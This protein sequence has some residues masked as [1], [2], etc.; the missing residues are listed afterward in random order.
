MSYEP[1][2][3]KYRP[4]TFKDLVGQ[5]AI[6]NTLIN[7]IELEKIAPA[8]LFTGPRGTGKT[9]SARIL[10][11]SLNCLA[12]NKPTA[13]P[14]GK[15]EVCKA[16]AS[17]N[18]LD[19]IE[20]DAASNTGVDN[21]REIIERSRFAP[22][23]SRYKVYAIDECLA[24]DSLIQTSEGLMRID[25]P[26]LKGKMVLSYNERTKTWEY[27]KVLRWLK[28]GIKETLII[29]TSD[30]KITCTGN[31]LIR[32]DR[33]WIEAK[34]VKEGM[35][36]LSPV[37]V[38]VER[39]STNTVQMEKYVDLQRDINL[40]EISTEVNH[41]NS[42]KFS[43]KQKKYSL[44]V[45]ADVKKSSMFP[46]FYKKKEKALK[47]FNLIGKG[48][49]IEK[50]TESGIVEVKTSLILPNNC[51]VISWDSFMEHC[52]EMEASI[53]P[54][55]TIDFLDYVGRMEKSNKH[56]WNIK[57][58]VY[59]NCVPNYKVSLIEDMAKNRLFVEQLVILS[60]EKFFKLS[61][62]TAKINQF[63][64]N[65]YNLLH[66]KDLLGGTWMT[67]LFN[68]LLKEVQQF[69]FTLKDFL[70]EK[71]KLLPIG[72]PIWDILPVPNLILENLHKKRTTTLSL[73]QNPAENG[74][75]ICNNTQ[76]PQWTTNL[77]RVE[78]VRHAGHEPVYDLEVED[79]HNFVANGLLVHN[80]HM[81]STAA[82]NALLKTL[83]EP[84]PQVVFI[85][86][87][88]DPQRVLSTIIS[89]CQRFD[90]R[91]IPLEAMVS[92]LQ[93]IADREN[94][95]IT[96]EALTLNAQIA[97]G[98]LRD[99]ESLLDQLSLF[100]EKITVDKI[101]DL[102]G[103]VPERDLL[104]LLTAIRKES[105]EDILAQCRNLLDRGREPLV[106]LQNLASFY[107]NL[108]IAKTS[109]S[110]RDLVAVTETCW[111][112][113]CTEAQY[114]QIDKILQGQ[115]HLKD[116][117][118]QIKHT[119]QPRLWLEVT[120][121]GLLSKAATPESKIHQSNTVTEHK[122]TLSNTQNTTHTNQ[123]KNQIGENSTSV[124]ETNTVR[125]D[126]H[127]NSVVTSTNNAT[128]H[129]NNEARSLTP[130]ATVKAQE[131][132]PVA[133][134]S[135]QKQPVERETKPQSLSTEIPQETKT[136]ENISTEDQAAIWQQV[137]DC[138]HPP[139]TQALLCQQCH[140]INLT[141]SAA[142]VG[143][144]SAKSQKLN[145]VRVPNIEAAF[146]KVCQRTIKVTLEVAGLPDG[147]KKNSNLTQNNAPQRSYTPQGVSN[148]P[149][150]H[151]TPQ[152]QNTSVIERSHSTSPSARTASPRSR[153][154]AKGR[155]QISQTQH[156]P[157]SIAATP[158]AIPQQEEIQ[159]N[160]VAPKE[161]TAAKNDREIRSQLESIG[162][163][164]RFEPTLSED[165]SSRTNLASS[166]N[167]DVD[168]QTKI[169]SNSTEIT[170]TIDRPDNPDDFA[171]AVE[172]VAQKF[173]GEIIELQDSFSSKTTSTT[174]LVAA[175]T[176]EL[177][178]TSPETIEQEIKSATAI[179]Q[180]ITLRKQKLV[181]NRDAI[182][183][184]A[185]RCAIA[186][187]D[188]D[189]DP[190]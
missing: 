140:L 69:F 35:K 155:P 130:Q 60:C 9:S 176:P 107:L 133:G 28:R 161:E 173:D 123:K 31:H 52:S 94:I 111:Q 164:E 8:Y 148:H 112:E 149:N 158:T 61:S 108:L 66:Q 36:I 180:E 142:V 121:L 80:C 17:G 151:P 97:N 116:G 81:L 50:V 175:E 65:G 84:P 122:P 22:V 70:K 38:D 79:N 13:N 73:E 150:S 43:N 134:A 105:I 75:Q 167:G 24:G 110:R 21:I 93:Y 77:E 82:F 12:N 14:C 56:G 7:A 120:L 45:N 137:I 96:T 152:A 44:C 87:T 126:S 25:D 83:E 98:G 182:S 92:H 27:K 172:L 32:T 109:P 64:W 58:V 88:T 89:R 46:P 74:Y 104:T 63:P 170:P 49:H 157:P 124:K 67:A 91:R 144:S 117:E 16:I 11:K 20:I 169:E 160:S 71:T 184:K 42:E 68:S 23:Q 95:A 125:D 34:N 53:I 115:Q 141:D 2:H 154:A 59:N 145:Q 190:F 139:I 174:A 37:S 146:A 162:T 57:R 62:Q 119:T 189:D 55:H 171:K 103:A 18:A 78:S 48:I 188:D 101:W 185:R 131:Q 178:S 30:R 138:I 127:L 3:H 106:L 26:D 166:S 186:D 102:V 187:Y 165:V 177:S 72:L 143:I 179:I 5:E 1:L 19:T 10:A 135:V 100:P 129:N 90:Y 99:A 4:Q 181:I 15:C 114:W 136:S 29:K 6:A 156:T 33:G 54:T 86:A 153:S 76:F 40:K 47:V 85:L 128:S 168:I 113:L 51:R 147:G 118:V 41:T 163:T 183:L 132:Q 159:N 39:I